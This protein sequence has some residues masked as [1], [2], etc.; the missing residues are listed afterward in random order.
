MQSR[1]IL[2]RMNAEPK[3]LDYA[4]K[5]SFLSF[6]GETNTN[7]QQDMLLITRG[8]IKQICIHAM[9]FQGTTTTIC[10]IWND[11]AYWLSSWHHL[12]NEE[13]FSWRII[14]H[15]AVDHDCNNKLILS[16]Q[17][18]SPDDLWWSFLVA[19]EHC[20]LRQQLSNTAIKTR[21]LPFTSQCC[22][23]WIAQVISAP[24]CHQNRPLQAHG[25]VLTANSSPF[26]DAHLQKE[27]RGW[28]H[29]Q[30]KQQQGIGKVTE[31]EEIIV[32]LLV[33]VQKKTSRKKNDGLDRVQLVEGV[34]AT[35]EPIST[36]PV[37]YKTTAK[38]WD[39]K[40]HQGAARAH[41]ACS[42]MSSLKFK[43]SL[44]ACN[45]TLSFSIP[46]LE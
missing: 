2:Q 33:L 34:T 41:V 25:T 27:W 39:T 3:L 38:T 6:S 46:N 45:C 26:S 9:E 37:E 18:W 21:T 32:H 23:G 19:T 20:S 29:P 22:V 42:K 5:R 31:V 4:R 15:W 28:H 1:T 12:S 11:A 43:H 35:A 40:P 13:G 10:H 44:R 14:E 8:K 7:L 30:E 24:I 36:K 16:L 17:R